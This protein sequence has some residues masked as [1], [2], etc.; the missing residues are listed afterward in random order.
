MFKSYANITIIKLAG[1]AARIQLD[2]VE[3]ET[4]SNMV[5]AKAGDYL[6]KV[7]DIM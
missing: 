2:P 3:F 6:K 7:A 5:D 4:G 1:E